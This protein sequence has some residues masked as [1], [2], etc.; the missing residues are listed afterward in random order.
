MASGEESEFERRAKASMRREEDRALSRTASSSTASW[1]SKLLLSSSAAGVL[2]YFLDGFAT[3]AL[4][5]VVWLVSGMVMRVVARRRLA[6]G[7]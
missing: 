4:L 6:A 1:L 7:S 3:A 2:G 5:F